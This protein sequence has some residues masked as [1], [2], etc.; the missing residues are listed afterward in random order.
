MKKI[1][2]VTSGHFSKDDRLYYKFALSL[3]KFGHRVEIIST[4][5]DQIIR[6]GSVTINSFDA[7]NAGRKIKAEG[8]VQ[9]LKHFMPDIIL[10]AE[11]FTVLPA[12]LFRKKYSPEVRIILDITELYPE[13]ITHK[14]SGLKKLVS[15]MVLWSVSVIATY[16]ADALIVGE[17]NK[18]GRYR[19]I[20]PGI[21]YKT[22]GYSV[23][24]SLLPESKPIESGIITIT[25][26]G[27]FTKA[28]GF[29][30]YLELIKLFTPEKY[31]LLR[32]QAIGKF[33]S[34][35]EKENYKKLST[36]DTQIPLELITWDKYENYLKVISESSLLID[37]RDK[38]SFFDRSLPIKIFDYIAAGKPFIF[39]D[40]EVFQHHPELKDSGIFCD[41]DDINSIMKNLVILI[42][43][44]TLYS[45]YCSRNK[46]IFDSKLNWERT[47]KEFV[48]FVEES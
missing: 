37:L 26:S 32:F 42:K 36:S 4:I 35:E 5:E 33:A 7:S 6:E 40:L 44:E 43:D 12:S 25:Y 46:M 17:T 41:P 31:P 13:N 28:R 14:L 47:E 22:F 29:F 48:E 3:Q 11:H 8:I 34:M 19:I 20:R 38:S 24:K 9:R 16:L 10:C 1:A 45:E 21:K 27:L 15:A 2:I 30:R 39:S 23:P 18:A